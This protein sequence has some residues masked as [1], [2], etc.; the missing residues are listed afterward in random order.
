MGALILVANLGGPTMFA[1]IG[2][3]KALN[4]PIKR[5]FNPDRKDHH[6]GLRKLNRD[7]RRLEAAL[8]DYSSGFNSP[9]SS[10]ATSGDFGG[11]SPSQSKQRNLRPPL[12]TSTNRMDLLHFRHRGGGVFLAMVLTLK[13]ARVFRSQSP[14]NCRGREVITERCAFRLLKAS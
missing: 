2:V 12:L 8:L 10:V 13:L 6:S 14:F 4:R 1:R 7:T 9:L 5:V 3:M 11:S